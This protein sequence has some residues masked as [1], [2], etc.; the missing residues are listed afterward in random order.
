MCETWRGILIF[1]HIYNNPDTLFFPTGYVLLKALCHAINA[2]CLYI[3]LI[4]AVHAHTISEQR[5]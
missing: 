5:A 1:M 4:E 2:D 3:I